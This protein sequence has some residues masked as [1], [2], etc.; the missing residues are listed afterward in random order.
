MKNALQ[1]VLYMKHN[2]F[3][4][5]EIVYV[6]DLDQDIDDEIVAEKGKEMCLW[7]G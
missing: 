4:E 7:H 2:E 5:K 3:Y 1:R 6:A